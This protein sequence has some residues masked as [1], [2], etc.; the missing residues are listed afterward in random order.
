MRHLPLPL[1]LPLSLPLPL[2]LHLDLHQAQR[3]RIVAVHLP[4][5]QQAPSILVKETVVIIQL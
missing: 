1:P 4:V 5:S 3:Q 2:P